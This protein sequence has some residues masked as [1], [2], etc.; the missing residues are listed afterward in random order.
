MPEKEA[1]SKHVVSRRSLLRGGAIAGALSVG[2]AMVG[3]AGTFAS[4]AT[5][6]AGQKE[7]GP[8]AP[9]WNG[10]GPIIIY[11]SDLSSGQLEI[12]AGTSKTQHVDRSLAQRVAALAPRF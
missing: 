5:V 6:K 9:E 8:Q 2:A 1:D 4:A 7:W 3:G 12:F 11:V 10:S